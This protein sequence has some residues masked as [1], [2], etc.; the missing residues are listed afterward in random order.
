MLAEG[1]EVNEFRG[2]AR[3]KGGVGRFPGR[4]EAT[5]MPQRER[6]SRAAVPQLHESPTAIPVDGFPQR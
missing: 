1:P 6:A 5:R 2:F 3:R 4:L